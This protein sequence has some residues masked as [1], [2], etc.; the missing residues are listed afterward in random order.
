MMVRARTTSSPSRNTS[1]VAGIDARDRARDQDLRPEPPGLLERAARKLVARDAAGKA[2]IVLDARGR[3]GLAAGR[4]AL[5]DDR[6]QSFGCTVDRRRE[7]GRPATDDRDVV[8]ARARRWSAGRGA[9]QC[10]APAGRLSTCAVGQPQHRAIAV[11]RARF[12]AR[13]SPV[14]AR[15]A[16]ANRRRSGC[17]RGTGASR[18]TRCPSGGRPSSRAAW[19]ARRRCPAARRCAR[20]RARRPSSEISG[21]AAATA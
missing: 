17:A 9:R 6:A 11:L 13:A 18:R 21:D 5:D 1:R 10:R 19:A 4:L 7:A 20:A 15:R 12:R 3:P 16:S 14:P 2:E 8:F